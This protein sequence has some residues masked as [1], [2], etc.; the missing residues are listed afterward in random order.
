[1]LQLLIGTMLVF[2]RDP[3]NL[4]VM[5]A[6]GV[7]AKYPWVAAAAGVVYG[8]AVFFLFVMPRVEHHYE[9]YAAA[10]VIASVFGMSL[11]YGLKLLVR[12]LLQV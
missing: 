2:L 1:M 5:L 8:L 7:I 11:A 3:L 9:V 4:V 12:R 10:C 6:C